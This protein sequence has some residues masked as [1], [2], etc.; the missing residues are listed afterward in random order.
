M[1][2]GL[3]S[4]SHAVGSS[5]HLDTNMP[6]L[7]LYMYVQRHTFVLGAPFTNVYQL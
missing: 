3:L 2:W 5:I 4:V 1:Q 6:T 7:Y